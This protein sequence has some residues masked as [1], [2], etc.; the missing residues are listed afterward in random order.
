MAGGGFDVVIGQNPYALKQN[1]LGRIVLKEG[2][3]RSIYPHVSS[4]AV[5][6]IRYQT[7]SFA[8]ILTKT[9]RVG[10]LCQKFDVMLRFLEK[11]TSN[12]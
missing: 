11:A 10:P 4:S 8:T 12:V 7:D 6:P 9:V 1:R 2:L 5:L 3:M